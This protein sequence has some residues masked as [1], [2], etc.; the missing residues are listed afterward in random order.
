M[1]KPSPR[2]PATPARSATAAAS[3][4]ATRPRPPRDR[5]AA[6]PHTPAP[7]AGA[8]PP[9]AAPQPDRRA[10]KGPAAPRRRRRPRYRA[11][12]PAASASFLRRSL[13]PGHGLAAPP[14]ATGHR[15]RRQDTPLLT[16]GSIGIGV[17]GIASGVIVRSR[18]LA[19]RLRRGAPH[20]LEAALRLLRLL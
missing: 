6:A 16:G 9:E 2:P 15:A 17:A 18:T 5:P 1:S 3:L 10:H 14:R 8:A 13:G 20:P 11:R 19:G 4:P 7:P 12:R